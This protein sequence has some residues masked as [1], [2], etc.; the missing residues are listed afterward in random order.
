MEVRSCNVWIRAASYRAAV[1][2]EA[3][4]GQHDLWS[5]LGFRASRTAGL[6]F[7]SEDGSCVIDVKLGAQGIRD[8]HGALVQLAV[9]L[10]EHP[11]TRQA[12]LVI[13]FPRMSLEVGKQAWLRAKR[14]LQP[15]LAKRIGLVLL[16][17]AQ[18]P[19]VDPPDPMLLRIAA[20]MPGAPTPVSQSDGQMATSRK[21][22]EVWKVLLRAWLKREAP[23]RAQ[24]LAK[25]AG[26]SYPTVLRCISFLTLRGELTSASTPAS[27]ELRGFPTTTFDQAVGLSAGLRRTR[28]FVDRSGRTPE[29]E[30]LARRL[31]RRQIEG[32]A[33]GGVIAARAFDPRLDLHGTPRLDLSY[34]SRSTGTG[35]PDFTALDPALHPSPVKDGAV[36]AV[37]RVTRPQ[38]FF[39]AHSLADPVEVLLDL[40]ELRL[41]AQASALVQHLRGGES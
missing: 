22:F 41:G 36:L 26:C 30:V 37:H 8:L 28:W 3:D 14:L 35:E 20:S 9:H 32:V 29:P 40:H 16:V 39:E 34:W 19:W 31:Q 17:P 1:S 4:L 23:M 2:A 21:F 18:Q 24:Q 11:E 5:S 10:D 7:V 6:D 13:R 38:P 12:I 25:T 33:I 15:S 27:L